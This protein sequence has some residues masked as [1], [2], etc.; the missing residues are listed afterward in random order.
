MISLSLM[1][2]NTI[3]DLKKILFFP[4]FLF[5]ESD[6]CKCINMLCDKHDG[7]WINKC[8]YPEVFKHDSASVC[9][10]C[11]DV[12]RIAVLTSTFE[13]TSHKKLRYEKRFFVYVLLS[14]SLPFDSKDFKI[15]Q[16]YRNICILPVF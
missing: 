7:Q 13:N 6:W 16:F 5:F 3:W 2:N 8:V 15:F 1:K 11:I 10:Q 4:F 14:L 12:S 9:I